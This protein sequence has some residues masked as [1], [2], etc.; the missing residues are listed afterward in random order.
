MLH[1]NGTDAAKAVAAG[2]TGAYS[3]ARVMTVCLATSKR[4]AFFRRDASPEDLPLG[5]THS[6]TL[7]QNLVDSNHSRNIG[8]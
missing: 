2:A 1:Q 3:A 5:L 8:T 4:H 7:S 6:W